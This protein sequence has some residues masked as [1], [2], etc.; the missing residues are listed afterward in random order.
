LIGQNTAYKPRHWLP[1]VPILIAAMAAGA[2]ALAPRRLGARAA[3]PPAALVAILAAQ[4]FADGLSLARGH[5]APSPAAAI[6]AFL[7]ERAGD[8]RPILTRDLGR[9]IEEGAPGQTARRVV[10][11]DDLLRA[12]EQAGAGGALITGEALSQDA[13]AA[14]AARGYAVSVVFA[15]PR[16][17][18]IDALWNELSLF[19]ATP[20]S[21]GS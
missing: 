14:L 7:R 21:P 1:L 2:G 11:D 17:R 18:Y 15:R 6:V 8:P 13:R 12:V 5:V 10:T 3:L 4:W 20:V 9:M 19:S 16:S